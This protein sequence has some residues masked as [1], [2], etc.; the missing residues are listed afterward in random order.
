MRSPVDE[1]KV[2][3]VPVG[4]VIAAAVMYAL[5]SATVSS[6]FAI[7]ALA[8]LLLL[9]GRRRKGTGDRAPDLSPEQRDGLREE[10]ESAGEVHAVKRLRSLHPQLSLGDA[11]KIVREL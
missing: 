6:I 8:T 5:G 9:S 11:V 10:R 2:L 1:R 7:L 4:L 3:V